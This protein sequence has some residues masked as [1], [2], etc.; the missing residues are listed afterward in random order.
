M[1]QGRK[2]TELQL[3]S[4]SEPGCFYQQSGFFVFS[5][6]KKFAYGDC[7]HLLLI[8]FIGEE[9]MRKAI[10]FLLFFMSA[11]DSHTVSA[12]TI[13][14]ING[15]DKIGLEESIYSLQV[16]SGIQSP[17]IEKV[18]LNVHTVFRSDFPGIGSV[19]SWMKD[20]I[21]ILSKDRVVMVDANSSF[22]PSEYLSKVSD[23]TVEAAHGYSGYHDITAGILFGSVPFGP[24]AIEY[25]AWFY[26]GNGL[27]LW[28]NLYE[29]NGYNVKV[30][31]CG[32][33]TA[34]TGGW[35]KSPVNNISDFNGLRMR[36]F[37]LAAYAWQKVGVTT[38]S[39]G[40]GEILSKLQDGSLD[41]AEFSSPAVDAAFIDFSTVA[42]Y[43]YFPGW[44]QPSLILEFVIN[45]DVWNGMTEHQQQAIDMTCR[46]AT[47]ENITYAE[48]IQSQYIK[49]NEAKG[50]HNLYFSNEIL[51]TMESKMD[52]VMAE[53]SLADSDFKT[54]W[55]DLS[56]FH[57]EYSTWLDLGFNPR[58]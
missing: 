53:Q 49:A 50:V 23:G 39:T 28:Q 15:D 27:T 37:G 33:N 1:R 42:S 46:A 16:A 48:S 14:D 10:L 25:L 21:G 12:E 6:T 11:V 34:E 44:H 5:W 4:A 22:S 41:A 2:T 32:V 58:R 43:N 26:H 45:K 36:T 7:G 17:A 40:A 54:I 30:M 35:F 9:G 13:G 24:E 20:R 55:T 38:E 3:R 51:T 56:E 8:N 29:D 47:L 31:P 52:E 19:F 18:T 57:Q